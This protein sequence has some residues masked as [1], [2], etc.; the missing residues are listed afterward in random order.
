MFDLPDNEIR[1]CGRIVQDAD[2]TALSKLLAE[3]RGDEVELDKE[4]RCFMIDELHIFPC[5]PW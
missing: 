5:R 3:K 4:V 1:M 2:R